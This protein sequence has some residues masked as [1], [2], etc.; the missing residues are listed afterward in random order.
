[1]A[2]A[3]DGPARVLRGEDLAP[4]GRIELDDDAD[5]IRVDAARRR[6]LVATARALGPAVRTKAGEIHL[7]GHPES[8][9]IDE[10]GNQDVVNVPEAREV[11]VV[12]LAAMGTRSLPTPGLGSNFCSP[13]TLMALST[14]SGR[15]TAEVAT[16][17]TPMMCLS[18][19]SGDVC[20]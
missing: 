17:A 15:V 2:N 20:T 13:P 12:D 7:K 19:P 3:G 1:V 6:V 4:I 11:T 14:Q 5:N 18:M 10:T 16:S 9:Q 8:F